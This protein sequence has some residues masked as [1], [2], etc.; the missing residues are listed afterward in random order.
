MV[1]FCKTFKSRS[2]LKNDVV[3]MPLTDLLFLR[4]SSIK[5]CPFRS[6][7]DFVYFLIDGAINANWAVRA[8]WISSEAYNHR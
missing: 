1:V 6:L 4:A 2:A 7:R 8:D 3:E 5:I